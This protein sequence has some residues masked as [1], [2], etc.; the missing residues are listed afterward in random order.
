[1]SVPIIINVTYNLV[2]I[3][4]TTSSQ[5][6]TGT[7]RCLEFDIVH[8]SKLYVGGR[9]NYTTTN[10]L[11]YS[12]VFL[13]LITDAQIITFPNFYPFII[14]QQS[15]E[16][17]TLLSV[18]GSVPDKSLLYIGGDCTY[19]PT[20]LVTAQP[21]D[22]LRYL[23]LFNPTDNSFSPISTIN[24]NPTTTSVLFPNGIV[25]TIAIDS[26][27][28]LYIGGDF[29]TFSYIDP[30]LSNIIIPEIGVG[31]Y[32]EFTNGTWSSNLYISGS[33]DSIIFKNKS[34]KTK[35]DMLVGGNFTIGSNYLTGLITF[36][37]DYINLVVDNKVLITLTGNGS[38]ATIS[39]NEVCGKTSGFLYSNSAY[40]SFN[41]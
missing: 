27:G 21:K 35:K 19:I 10:G 26:V 31:K 3:C 11:S 20:P 40:E 32:A 5:I 22:T 15:N 12:G 34:V 28:T 38:S 16:A 39:S 6:I 14:N 4:G 33:I 23:I 7:V 18:N 29:N 13:G 1:M 30:A 8:Q 25:R 24:I 17:Y 37:N 2:S 9:I 36:T 41:N